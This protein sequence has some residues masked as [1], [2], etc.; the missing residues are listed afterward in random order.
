MRPAQCV[1]KVPLTTQVSHL[2]RDAEGLTLTLGLTSPEVASRLRA[3]ACFQLGCWWPSS[4]SQAWW[5]AA[6]LRQTSCWREETG[7]E[8]S[9]QPPRTHGVRPLP[10]GS[11]HGYHPGSLQGR[12]RGQQVRPTALGTWGGSEGKNW[13]LRW[14]RSFWIKHL[15]VV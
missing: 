13:G 5:R 2:K 9:H 4:L 15:A 1:C 10:G 7:S 6:P 12:P 11:S 3:A 8:R 14:P